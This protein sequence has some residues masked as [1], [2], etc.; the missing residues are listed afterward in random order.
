MCWLWAVIFT[1][2]C[3][4]ANCNQRAWDPCNS[5]PILCKGVGHLETLC[6]LLANALNCTF[7]CLCVNLNLKLYW[8]IAKHDPLQ[9]WKV[10][11]SMVYIPILQPQLNCC[12][13]HHILSSGK[14][15]FTA[16]SQTT[17]NAGFPL[18]VNMLLLQQWVIVK[19]LQVNIASIKIMCQATK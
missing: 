8:C 11:R 10:H 18:K 6:F 17:S 5:F 19:Q 4:Y 12:S 1:N 15:H 9:S 7:T 14:D 13:S 3:F 2:N 16:F